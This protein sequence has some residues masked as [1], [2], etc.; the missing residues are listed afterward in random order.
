MKKKFYKAPLLMLFFVM[1]WNQMLAQERII[2]GQ[3]TDEMTGEALPGVNILAKG[4]SAGTITNLDGNYSLEV[5]GEANTLVFS[6][7]GYVTEEVPVGNSSEI[8]IALVPDM[9]SLEEVVVVG[10]GT[11]SRETLTSS[12]SKLDTKVLENVPLANAASA[13]QGTIAGVR[14]QT[15]TGQPGVSP[16][17]IVRG[18]TSINNPNGAQ[19][20]YI[21]DGVIRNN[22]DDINPDDIESLQVLKDAAATAIYGAR[23]SNGVVIVTT[24]TGAAGKTQISYRYNLSLSEQWNRY[25]M[26]SARDYIY[27]NRL[28]ILA[29]GEKHP[30]HLFRLNQPVGFGVG[31]DLTNNT[32]FTP[33]YLTAENEHKLAEGWQQMPDPANPDKTIIFDE[34]DWQDVLF[35]QAISHNHYISISGGSEKAR[36]DMGIGYLNNQGVAI[37]TDYKRFTARM[38]GDVQVKDKLAVYGKLNFSSSSNNQVYNENQ[39]FQRA[40]GLPPT[41]KLYYEDGSLAPG[42]NRSMGNPLYHLNR[43]EALNATNRLTLTTG[44]N[45]ELIPGLTFEPMASLYFVQSTANSFQKSFY[46]SPTQFIDSRAASAVNTLWWQKQFDAVFNYQKSFGLH[47]LQF[48]AGSSYFDRQNYSASAYGRGAAS[49]LIPTL[50]ASAEPTAVSSSAGAQVI[51]GY[52]GRATYD[53]DQKYLFSISSRYDGA[54]NL[55]KDN[56]W[57][58]FP[59]VSAGW[60]LHREN[61]W[62]NVPESISSLKLR[63]SYGVN[64]NIGNLS[65]FHAQGLYSVGSRYNDLAAI[66][67]NRMANQ[68]LQ[69]ERS[70]TFDIGFDL[71][72]LNNR[73]NLI[74]DYYNRVTDNLL[75]NLELPH[76]TGFSSILTNLGALGNEGVELEISADVLRTE[77][78]VWNI[79]ANGTYNENTILEL[80]ENENEFNRIGGEFVY[81]LASQDYV[82]K[83]GL[84]EG[85]RPGDMFAYQQLGVY[86]T[87]EQASEGSYDVLVTGADKSKFGGDVI[88]NDLD[89]N[90]TIDSRDRVYAGNIFPKW[91]GGFINSVSYGNFSLSIRT[92]FALGHTIYHETRARFNGQYQGDIGILEETTRAWQEQGDVTDIPR[93]YWADQLAQNN[94]FRGSTFYHER[95]D[96]LAIREVTM[97][98][99]LPKKWLNSIGISNMRTYLTGANLHYFTKYTGLNPEEGGSDYGRYPIPRSFVFGVNVNF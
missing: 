82:W 80:P 79:A 61:F 9:K 85:G 54:S 15:T 77:K 45:W 37:N 59:G 21:I 42:Q 71:G 14:V 8:D 7:I 18:G 19:P 41:T 74:F 29:T 87:D 44:M 88:W 53:F 96:Y 86:A 76:S 1:L 83:G 55:G 12:V 47:N 6:F 5:S 95:G 50:N 67:N 28:G 58:L 78:L 65:D 73:V 69:W 40:L 51:I 91:T 84:Q 4:S 97:S 3:V 36:F 27:F 30:Q 70:S 39:L 89:K 75:T 22:M 38:N 43:S 17:V 63:A 23:G 32:A 81:D 16:R 48:S 46:N 2:R 72:L 98:Y 24:K 93:Y 25:N 11:Q 62:G 90:D 60:N 56:Y 33:Q 92:D 99:N 13:M 52:F 68:N 20:L 49:D 35:R 64:G 57:G 66:M 94:S 26:A 10:Y 31:N 34:T